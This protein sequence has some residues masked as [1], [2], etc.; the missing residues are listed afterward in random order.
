MIHVGI[1]ELPLHSCFSVSKS[2]KQNTS[3]FVLEG[4]NLKDCDSG[5]YNFKYNK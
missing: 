5:E 1:H 3:N 4:I 2:Y